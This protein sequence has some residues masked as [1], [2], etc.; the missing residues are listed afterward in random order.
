VTGT[1][2]FRV[3][4]Y[5]GSALPQPLVE[6]DIP[7]G[8]TRTMCGTKPCW[9]L[10]GTMGFLYRDLAGSPHGIT[11]V[12]LHAG[13]DGAAFVQV[14]GR[15][16][17]LVLPDPGALSDEV[18]IQLVIDDGATTECFSSAFPGSSGLGAVSKQTETGFKAK[19]P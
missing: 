15:G 1:A 17:S 12:K 19:G 8:G 3:C 18:V 2:S 4:V 11:I 16:A 13:L 14:Q 10:A 9:G 6:L 5:D 7:S